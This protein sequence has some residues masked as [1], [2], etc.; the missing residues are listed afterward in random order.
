RPGG[1]KGLAVVDS[2]DLRVT[3][4]L[5]QSN[6]NSSYR[7]PCLVLQHS[8]SQQV[9]TKQI[10][11]RQRLY[12]PAVLSPKPTFE[13]HRPDLVASPSHRQFRPTQ[14]RPFGRTPT[15]PTQLHPA[16]PIGNRPHR[17]HL[18]TAVL[19][20]QMSSQLLASPT[21]VP[22]PQLPNPPHPLYR[23]LPRRPMR[24]TT[25][26][27][28]ALLPFALEPPFPLVTPLPTDPKAS[29]ELGHAFLGLQG[30]LHKLQS[31]HHRRQFFPRHASE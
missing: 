24:T 28:Q 3:I 15:A 7:P 22:S 19:S 9:T 17:R 12:S 23:K 30:Q 27:A 10:P 21:S 20:T 5:K 6:K 1:S 26:I 4:L 14:S 13:V 25:A 11:N 31:P 2:D 8:N 29:T 16:Q 18:L